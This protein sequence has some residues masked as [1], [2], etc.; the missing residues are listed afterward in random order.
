A[1]IA[2]MRSIRTFHLV[3]GLNMSTMSTTWCASLC[4]LSE[5]AWPVSATIGARS[6]Q[7]SAMPVRRLVAPGPR[8]P[9]ATAARPVRRPY[10]SAMNAAPC[11]WRTVMWRMASVWDKASRTSSVSSPGTEKTYSQPSASR[12]ATSRS[13]AVRALAS[14][15]APAAR[16]AKDDLVGLREDHDPQL[17]HVLDGPAQPLAALA[18][19]LHTAVGHVIDAVGRDVV[20]DDPADLE[21]VERLPG[22]RE[23]VR[24]HA[25]LQPEE[26]VVDLPNRVAEVG[27]REYD[28]E[29]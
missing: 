27:E 7:A 9:M 25:G 6:R 18:G 2:G 19:V 5:D 14:T 16:T 26:A 20:D 17:G 29:R 23:V 24:E 22:V 15:R 3:T 11:S 10:T 13:A 8:V 1:G 21:L 28:D 4:S 12:Q